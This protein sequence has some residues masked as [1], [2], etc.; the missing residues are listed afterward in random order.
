MLFQLMDNKE[1][2]LGYCADGKLVFDDELPEELSRTWKYS[3][4]LVNNR[5][6]EYAN[7]YCG[8]LPMEQVCPAHLQQRLE[9]H[10]IKLKAFLRSFLEAKVSLDEN[11]FFDLMPDKFLLNYYDVKNEITQHVLDNYERPENYKLLT[12]LAMVLGDIR[13]RPLNIDLSCL[14][15]HMHQLPAKNFVQKI[16]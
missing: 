2:R 3:P 16:V 5:R 10:S 11:C 9:T 8:G 14:R 13:S 15:E 12:R 1:Q 7:L 4:A 6:I